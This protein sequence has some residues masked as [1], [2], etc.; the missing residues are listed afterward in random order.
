MQRR[1]CIS[2]LVLPCVSHSVCST[3]TFAWCLCYSHDRFDAPLPYEVYNN[4]DDIP[5][6]EATILKDLLYPECQSRTVFLHPSQQGEQKKYSYIDSTAESIKTVLWFSKKTNLVWK[7]YK[8]KD[9][10]RNILRK[11]KYSL[12]ICLQR[13]VH[14]AQGHLD[15]FRLLRK[16]ISIYCT[17]EYQS[18]CPVVWSGS[19]HPSPA[20]ECG[21]PPSGP[22]WEDPIQTTGQ[23]LW[24][25][26]L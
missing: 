8:S 6:E 14:K 18:A 11:Y 24:Y 4:N 9:L 16:E 26:V 19:F 10:E 23:T 22:K 7:A 1:L 15:F 2:L 5:S 13:K 3:T 17:V 20:S 12:Q 21:F 25:F